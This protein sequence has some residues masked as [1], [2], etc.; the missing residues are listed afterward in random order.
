MI[1]AYLHADVLDGTAQMRKIPDATVLVEDGKVCSVQSGGS[2]PMKCSRVDLRGKTLLPG[3]INLHCHLPGDGRPQK[4]DASTAELIQKQ[5]KSP[6]GR[7]VMKGI[8]ASSAKTELLSGTTTIRTV[9]GLSD[10][11]SQLRDEIAAGKRLGPRI[12]ASDQAISVPGGHMAGTLA[13]ISHSKEETVNLVHKIAAGHPDLIK[14]MITAGT[15][16]IEKPGDESRILMPPEQ[17]KAACEAAH[18]LG[19]PVAAHV[20]GS[21]GMRA[22]LEN[23]VDTIEHGGDMDDALISLFQ[24]KKASLVSTI[25]VVASMACL[26]ITLSKLPALYQESC[27][28]YL[29]ELIAGYRKAVAA[30]IPMGMGLDNGSPLITQYCM[31]RELDF[32]TRYIG[33]PPEFA[34]HTATQ[35]NARILGLGDTLGAIEAGKQ[36]DF[37]IV[38]GNPLKDFSCLAAPFMVV[39]AGR[40]YKPRFHRFPRYDR[41]LDQVKEYDGAYLDSKGRIDT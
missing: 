27:S 36:A 15:L 16:D 26:P 25:T 1:T 2:L 3:L 39:K 9:G 10:M 40:N 38:D 4:I 18:A 28:I 37:L 31:W 32:F 23:G 12:L 11:D 29:H 14:L 34:L 33:T 20:Q 19:L 5:L 35:G 21:A 13:Y 41:L 30:G 6:I 17:I 22:A 8:S 24:E 7:A